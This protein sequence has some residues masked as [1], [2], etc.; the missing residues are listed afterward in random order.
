[1]PANPVVLPPAAAEHMSEI[2]Q[3]R[4]IDHSDHLPIETFSTVSY[5]G[6]NGGVLGSGLFVEVDPNTWVENGIFT[7][8]EVLENENMAVLFDPSRGLTV[9][10]DYTTDDITISWGQNQLVWDLVGVSQS[11]SPVIPADWFV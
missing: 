5:Q 6:F 7:F 8:E 3:G 1:M 11:L 2:A 9:T 4:L 10:I